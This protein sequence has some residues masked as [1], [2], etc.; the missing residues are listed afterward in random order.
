MHVGEQGT[1]CEAAL[2]FIKVCTDYVTNHS[3]AQRRQ[4]TPAL[5]PPA[6]K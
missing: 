4:E 5:E 6:P 2:V 1:A 3:K